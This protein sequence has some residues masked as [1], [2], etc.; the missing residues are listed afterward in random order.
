[1]N[2]SG[3]YQLATKS[4]MPMAKKF[5]KW[6]FEDVLPSIRKTGKYN[7]VDNCF[8]DDNDIEDFKNKNVNYIAY[9]GT[10][11]GKDYYKYGYTDNFIERE[12]AHL[13]DY[14]HFITKYVGKCIGNKGIESDFERHLD[15]YK[16]RKTEIINEKKHKELFITT[17]K[18][19]IVKL[20]EKMD[21]LI[22]KHNK[23]Y[24]KDHEQDIIIANTTKQIEYNNID[25]MLLVEQEKTKQEQER[26]RQEIL[27][28][29]ACD[30]L[31]REDALKLLV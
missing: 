7:I 3:L 20:I 18:H 22:E 25:N 8:F 29:L 14:D 15:R 16:I 1:M 4:K 6:L 26:T 17:D 31:T 2:E 19:T 27:K 21:H 13:K 28:L 10:Y 12:K 24:L 23:R 9:V 11:K 30:K 5:Q